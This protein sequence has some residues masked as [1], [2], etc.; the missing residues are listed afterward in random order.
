MYPDS[1]YV[2]TAVGIHE[3]P[4]LNGTGRIGF[5]ASGRNGGLIEGVHKKSYVATSDFLE[6]LY[7]TKAM[8]VHPLNYALG[9]A[10]AARAAGV[11]I[12][13]NSR[14]TTYTRSG[15]ATVST[16]DGQVEASF[17]VLACNGY[18]GKLAGTYI[19]GWHAAALPGH[20]ARHA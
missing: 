18:L 10:R 14:V 8:S 16:Q 11:R 9:L 15:P 4:Q 20:G 17:I 1:Y 5:G 7:D 2:A 19:P 13:E 3:H 6:G 12:S